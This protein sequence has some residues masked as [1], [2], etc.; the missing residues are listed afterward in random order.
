VLEQDAVHLVYETRSEEACD[1]TGGGSGAIKSQ[2][3]NPAFGWVF[4]CLSKTRCVLRMRLEVKKLATE[5][6]INSSHKDKFSKNP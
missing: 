4:L 2:K 6:A 5:P 3:Y 1:R